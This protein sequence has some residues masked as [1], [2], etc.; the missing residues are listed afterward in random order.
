[1]IPLLA[2]AIPAVAGGVLSIMGGERANRQSARSI[3]EQMAFQERMSNTAHQREV[4]DLRAAGLNPILSATG[5]PGASTPSGASM[6]FEDTLSRG[7][8]SALAS[9]NA[10]L[11]WKAMRQAIANAEKQHGNIVADTELKNQNFRVAQ[12]QEQVAEA[13]RASLEANTALTNANRDVVQAGL[14]AAIIEG[15]SA[16]GAARAFG[17]L[18]RAISGAASQIPGWLKKALEALQ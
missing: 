16:A 15:S 5:G 11:E 14:P 10:A 13:T 2:A 17:G 7:V 12:V 4:A 6:R 3:R 1:M 9:K 8:S 18:G